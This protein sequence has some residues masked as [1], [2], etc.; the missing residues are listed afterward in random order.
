MRRKKKQ[1]QEN[2]LKTPRMKKCEFCDKNFDLN[3][4]GWAI[5]MSPQFFCSDVCMRENYLRSER[6]RK[7]EATWTDL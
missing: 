4:D 1:P 2:Y 7:G 6:I 5:N 3:G